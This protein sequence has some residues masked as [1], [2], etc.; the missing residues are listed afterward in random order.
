MPKRNQT[1]LLPSIPNGRKLHEPYVELCVWV[2]AI[3]V[4]GSPNLR[5][6]LNL[7]EEQIDGTHKTN[8]TLRI[9]AHCLIGQVAPWCV[10]RE[11]QAVE[12]EI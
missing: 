4:P 1:E 12:V 7:P 8:V 3:E 6:A 9:P 2:P 5:L 11:F 10:G